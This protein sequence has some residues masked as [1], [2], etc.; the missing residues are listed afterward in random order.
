MA[1]AAEY[2]KPIT[3]DEPIKRGETKITEVKLR[4]PA[5]G[6]LR[7]LNLVNLMNGDVDSLIKVLPRISEPTL[8]EQDVQQME[9]CDL[10]QL[11]DTV[12][13]FLQPKAVRAQASQST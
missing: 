8:T 4:K 5:S 6:E 2:S 1:K 12:A 10:V 9:P 3:L 7:G 11:G 13:V